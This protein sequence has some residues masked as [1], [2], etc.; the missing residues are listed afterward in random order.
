MLKVWGF[1]C[2]LGFGLVWFFCWLVGLGFVWPFGLVWF[3]ACFVCL[4]GFLCCVFV[5]VYGWS[6][7]VCL[8]FVFKSVLEFLLFST[9]W[10]R[11]CAYIGCK[12]HKR[13]GEQLKCLESCSMG[14]ERD[15][16]RFLR[17]ARTMK[18]CPFAGLGPSV[19]CRDAAASFGVLWAATSLT[20]RWRSRWGGVGAK[21]QIW[22]REA[23]GWN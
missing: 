19:G 7:C 2:L 4:W 14:K 5:Y 3:G 22:I 21:A 1:W 12:T 15:T 23:A 9:A 17:A 10:I 6:L 18:T 8:V 13:A 20:W 16:F 11:P